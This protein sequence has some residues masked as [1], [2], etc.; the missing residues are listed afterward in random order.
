M[1]V[2]RASE[3]PHENFKIKAR[4]N[5]AVGRLILSSPRAEYDPEVVTLKSSLVVLVGDSFG[6]PPRLVCLPER[7][8]ERDIFNRNS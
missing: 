7:L 5:L 2:I 3:N 4:I 8:L 1:V 6:E